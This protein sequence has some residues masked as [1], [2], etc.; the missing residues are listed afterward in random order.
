MNVGYTD[1]VGSITYLEP[2]KEVHDHECSAGQRS[3]FYTAHLK[4]VLCGQTL[5]GLGHVH[6]I[7]ITIDPCIF[8]PWGIPLPVFY[9]L[10]ML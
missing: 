3:K 9:C 2:N 4:I 7:W 10:R 5:P 6:L 1:V 8:W